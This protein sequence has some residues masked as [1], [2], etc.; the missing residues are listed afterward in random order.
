MSNILHRITN[1]KS[2]RGGENCS[3]YHSCQCSKN[4][5]YSESHAPEHG[6][7]VLSNQPYNSKCCYTHRRDQI[8]GLDPMH[9]EFIIH[10]RLIYYYINDVSFQNLHCYENCL[11]WSLFYRMKCSQYRMSKK[12]RLMI[13]FDFSFRFTKKTIRIHINTD[14]VFLEKFCIV[15]GIPK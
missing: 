6:D 12:P 13:F 5:Q 15:Q 14:F 9:A 1:H 11:N 10:V 3:I 7:P 8:F 2:Q 4:V